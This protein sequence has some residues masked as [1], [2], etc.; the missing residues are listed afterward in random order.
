MAGAASWQVVKKNG[1]APVGRVHYSATYVGQ[2]FYIFGGSATE[3]GSSPSNE[4]YTL[5]IKKTGAS[6]GCDWEKKNSGGEAPLPVSRHTAVAFG[7]RLFI[8][9]GML[10]DKKPTD[11]LRIWNGGTPYR[12]TRLMNLSMFMI[13]YVVVTFMSS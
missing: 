5:K 11:Q 1:P 6:D 9:G 4:L 8:F 2:T 12:N 7:L 3:D 13:S 10:A